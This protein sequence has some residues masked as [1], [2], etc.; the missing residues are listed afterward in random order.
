MSRGPAGGHR[1]E[2]AMRSRVG[3][4]DVAAQAGVSIKT[5][6]NVVNNTGS[7]TDSTRKRV[8]EAIAALDYRPNL[9]ARHLRRGSSGLIAVAL[10]ELTQPYF[11]ELAAELVR[12]AKARGRMVLLVQTEG[13]ESGERAMLEGVDLPVLDGLVLSPLALDGPTLRRRTDRSPLVLLGE[14]VGDA[15]FD[16][17]TI[18]NSA[19]AA[20]ATGH[21]LALGRRRIAAIGAQLSGPNETAVLRLAGYRR[22][23]AAAGV[24][25]DES[26]VATV[27]QFHRA[28]GAAAMARLLDLPDPPDAVFCFNDALALGA[29][30]ALAERGVRV[31]H[32]VAVV[33]VDDVEEGRFATPSLTTIAPDKRALATAAIDLVLRGG[34]AAGVPPQTLTV[35]HTLAVRESTAGRNPASTAGSRPHESEEHR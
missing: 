10:P 26:L 25:E 23:L 17:V 6:S 32:D 18:D 4:R 12:A 9:A 20:T 24:A 11:A 35:A 33:G 28:D 14:H 2:G 34:A 13:T 30:R 3:L 21:L 1:K 19:A 29:L 27:D 8:E 31:P 5:V 15:V 22:A 7:V 16:H